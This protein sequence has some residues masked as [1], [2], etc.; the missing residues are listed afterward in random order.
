MAPTPLLTLVCTFNATA[1]ATTEI[2]DAVIA[3]VEDAE[4][5]ERHNGHK[6][7]ASQRL[8]E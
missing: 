1:A 8:C 4:D 7:F 5:V 6:D 2:V 3:A